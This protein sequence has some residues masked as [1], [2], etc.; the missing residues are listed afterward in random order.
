MNALVRFAQHGLCVWLAFAGTTHD[1]NAAVGERIA[2]AALAQVGVTTH[3]DPSY[4]RLDYPMGDVAPDTGV[5]ADVIVRALRGVDLDLQRELHRDMKAAFPAYPALWGLSRP[6][7]NIDHRRV[8]NLRRWFERQG[9]SRPQSSRSDDYL[10]G[11]IVSWR[12]DSGLAHIGI[13]TA[14]LAPGTHRPL[15]V[16]NIAFGA[17][18]QDVLFAWEITGHYRMPDRANTTAGR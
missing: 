1:S 13:V 9:W 8:P 12:L 2:D 14:R 7:H 15:L 10:P 6:D 3:Y 11:D 4:R 16:H 17:L 5:C 18:A